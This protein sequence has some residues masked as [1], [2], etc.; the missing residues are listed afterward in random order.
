MI[1]RGKSTSLTDN[2]LACLK[3]R[4]SLYIL[5]YKELKG[6]FLPS[7]ESVLGIFMYIER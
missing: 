7:T 4:D 2:G 6:I 5:P 1:K 3:L